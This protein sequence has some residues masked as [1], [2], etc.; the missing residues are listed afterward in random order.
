MIANLIS[1]STHAT[2]EVYQRRLCGFD[3]QFRIA[4]LDSEIGFKHVL[5]SVPT[6]A[7]TFQLAWQTVASE[8]ERNSFER[9]ASFRRAV[10]VHR[11]AYGHLKLQ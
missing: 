10:S 2:W 6:P 3:T 1:D 8:P 9:M 7:L 5:M 11:N 4:D